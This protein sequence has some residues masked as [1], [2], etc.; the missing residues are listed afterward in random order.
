MKIFRWLPLLLLP[1]S[2]SAFADTYL[3][4]FG[5]TDPTVYIASDAKVYEAK[6]RIAGGAETVIPALATPGGSVTVTATPGQ[7]IEV[8]GRATNKGLVSAWTSWVTATAPFAATQPGTQTGMT[9]TVSRT[10]P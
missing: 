2:F 6:Y 1:I 7:T 3:V 4:T 9:V 5:W 10:G 8:A